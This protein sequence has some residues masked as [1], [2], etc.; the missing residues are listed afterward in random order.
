MLLATNNLENI[1]AEE[2][3]LSDK[4]FIMLDQDWR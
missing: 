1:L 2:S 4:C 3:W